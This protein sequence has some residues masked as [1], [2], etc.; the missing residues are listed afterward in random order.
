[1]VLNV[2]VRRK[3]SLPKSPPIRDNTVIS[4]G[5]IQG[6]DDRLEWCGHGCHAWLHSNKDRVTG[7]VENY[8]DFMSPNALELRDLIWG[9]LFD[10]KL[11]PFP[12]ILDYLLTVDP[13][14][15]MKH[16]KA[17]YFT[18]DPKL[19]SQT[20][21][22]PYL[23]SFLTLLRSPREHHT[24]RISWA[25]ESVKYCPNDWILKSWKITMDVFNESNVGLLMAHRVGGSAR[26]SERLL[27]YEPEGHDV[28]GWVTPERVR[29]GMK[30]PRNPNSP[31]TCNVFFGRTDSSWRGV[32]DWLQGERYDK[33]AL[34]SGNRA[35]LLRNLLTKL[36]DLAE[37]NSSTGELGG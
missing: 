23:R 17:G 22:W 2:D 26:W 37:M 24:P 28:T 4:C 34:M 25:G 33:D 1:M 36:K 9:R 18:F 19:A 15:S 27:K 21:R 16:L 10:P 7:Y 30:R 3:L 12:D 29:H 31:N 14:F 5:I 20:F 35:E 8:V 11:T 32:P 13:Q 6:I